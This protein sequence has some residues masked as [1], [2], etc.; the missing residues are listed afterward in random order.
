MQV[1]L[2]T[3][4]FP[5]HCGHSYF[6]RLLNSLCMP[7]FRS[8][9]GNDEFGNLERGPPSLDI[10]TGSTAPESGVGRWPIA[11]QRHTCSLPANELKCR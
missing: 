5:A 6:Q 7:R 1:V 4:G 9:H 8:N 3:P 10:M 11:M 2:N